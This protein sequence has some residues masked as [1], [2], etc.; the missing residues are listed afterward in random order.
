MIWKEKSIYYLPTFIR[1]LTLPVYIIQI[2]E[3]DTEIIIQASTHRYYNSLWMFVSIWIHFP[4]I[5]FHFFFFLKSKK[6][7]CMVVFFPLT[8]EKY[9]FYYFSEE[10]EICPL[11]MLNN[12]IPRTNMKPHKK[13]RLRS[14]VL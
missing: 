14:F 9:L 1:S 7:I 12:Q 8:S 13:F 4:S 10:M 6:Y 11:S 2:I 3:T 5:C